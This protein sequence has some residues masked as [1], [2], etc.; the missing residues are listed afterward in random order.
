MYYVQVNNLPKD[1]VCVKYYPYPFKF[2]VHTLYVYEPDVNCFGV[3]IW[4]R[5]RHSINSSLGVYLSSLL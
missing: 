4:F 3:A 2:S 1:C 5:R